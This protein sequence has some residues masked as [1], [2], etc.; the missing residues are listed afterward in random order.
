MKVRMISSTQRILSSKKSLLKAQYELSKKL[1]TKRRKN[2]DPNIDI[3]DYQGN[4]N[5]LKENPSAYLFHQKV[6]IIKLEILELLLSKVDTYVIMN[7]LMYNRFE[8][9]S[10]KEI[11]EEIKKQE[12]P[13]LPLN[14]NDLSQRLLLDKVG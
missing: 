11:S 1:L 8:Y 7:L 14:V 2:K 6:S 10:I 9:M 3:W 13:K 4:E 12:K 5:V